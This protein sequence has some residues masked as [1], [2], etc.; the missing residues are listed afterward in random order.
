MWR[1]LLFAIVRQ[2]VYRTQKE[3][4]KAERAKPTSG[5]HAMTNPAMDEDK[6]DDNTSSCDV[7][8]YERNIR[9]LNTRSFSDE[10][11]TGKRLNSRPLENTGA[12]DTILPNSE[13]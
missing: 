12:R 2:Y 1:L 5:M 11:G 3:T 10:N 6:D 7:L 9:R 8:A 4:A 13:C